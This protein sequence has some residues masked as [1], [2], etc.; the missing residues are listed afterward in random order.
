MTTRRKK[1]QEKQLKEK[2]ESY[3]KS[4]LDS[5]EPRRW[6]ARMARKDLVSYLEE[7]GFE[8]SAAEQMVKEVVPND[9]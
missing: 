1:M 8:E 2:Y 9:D 3:L 4:R 5:H 7:L 6:A